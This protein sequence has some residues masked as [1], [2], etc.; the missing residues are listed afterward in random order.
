MSP[1]V[2]TSCCLNHILL[3]SKAPTVGLSAQT[4]PPQSWYERYYCRPEVGRKGVSARESEGRRLEG[5]IGGPL[6]P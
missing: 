2:E 5:S 4:T 1:L 3:H 6:E